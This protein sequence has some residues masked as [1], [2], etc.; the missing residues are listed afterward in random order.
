MLPK[1]MKIMLNSEQAENKKKTLKEKK[2]V[3]QKNR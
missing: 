3:L 2:P 1:F